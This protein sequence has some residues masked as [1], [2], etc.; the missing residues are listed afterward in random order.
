MQG[1]QQSS[2]PQQRENKSDFAI[3]SGFVPKA[4]QCNKDDYSNQNQNDGKNQ[5]I[6]WCQIVVHPVGSSK[7]KM[8]VNTSFFGGKSLKNIDST[9]Q[10]DLYQTKQQVN[11]LV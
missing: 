10:S 8:M 11:G 2:D 9:Q 7:S 6:L 4:E 3:N 1:K 5:R